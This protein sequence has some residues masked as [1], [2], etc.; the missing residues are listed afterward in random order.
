MV[1]ARTRVLLVGWPVA[2]SL[3]LL[4]GVGVLDPGLADPGPGIGFYRWA[5]GVAGAAAT[6]VL[7]LAAVRTRG[8]LRSSWAAIA[9]TSGLWTLSV[10]VALA[11]G[12]DL[13]AWGILRPASALAGAVA[14]IRAPGLRRAA[15]AWGLVVLDGWLVGGSVFLIGWLA[16]AG[17]GSRWTGGSITD[18][19]ALLWVPVDLLFVSVVAGLAMRTDRTTRMPVL[20]MV[21]VSLLS[22]TGDCTWALADSPAF[23][24]IQWIIMMGALAASTVSHRLDLW[25]PSLPDQLRPRLVRWPQVAV[26]PGL[27]AAVSGRAD[28]PVSFVAISVIV[29]MV[30]EILLVSRQNQELWRALAAQAVRLDLL[31]RESR[32]AIVQV[33]ERGLV[34]FANEAV[35]DVLGREPK[36]LVGAEFARCLHDDDRA[37]FLEQI[38]GLTASSGTGTTSVRVN[39]RVRHPDGTLRHVEATVSR[40][41]TATEP[42]ACLLAPA[43]AAGLPPTTGPPPTTSQRAGYTLLAR[44]VTERIRHET[45]LRHLASSDALTGLLNRYGFL[46]LLGERLA[47]GPAAVLFLD[48]DGFKTVNDL[49]G[50][51]VGDRLLTEAA[52]ALR[53]ALGVEDVASRLGGDEF[54]VLAGDADRTRACALAARITDRIGRLPSDVG[55]TTSASVGVAFGQGIRAEQLLADADL[56]MY[57]AKADGGGRYAVCEQP[58]RNALVRP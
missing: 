25:Q 40:R 53:G 22:V 36:A 44:D 50:H 13:L 55:R 45:E 35:T 37:R 41:L 15:R 4:L 56:A 58:R 17:T 1:V 11:H 49:H 6:A 31:V 3:V 28:R 26:V 10:L 27:A 9:L 23:A 51:A 47:A 38:A 20:M 32:D 8:R 21:L 39:S 43:G 5:V 52:Q 18:R 29:A 33:N 34:E 19:P 12:L 2:A 54:A 24:V 48:L 16:L 30:V 46:E 7:A 57:R 14:L 42:S